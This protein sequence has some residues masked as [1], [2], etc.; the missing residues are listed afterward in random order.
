VFRVFGRTCVVDNAKTSTMSLTDSP[1]RH[2]I[3]WNQSEIF[4]SLQFDSDNEPQDP[5]LSNLIAKRNIN[6]PTHYYVKVKKKL[7]LYP[8][9]THMRVDVQHH[10]I[11]TSALDEGVVSVTPPPPCPR[12]K[13]P[14]ARDDRRL[15]I[16]RISCSFIAPVYAGSLLTAWT[17]RVGL[18]HAWLQGANTHAR[19]S[20]TFLTKFCSHNNH[21]HGD[22]KKL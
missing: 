2:S 18:L 22:K 9:S 4:F 17:R 13:E 6:T 1:K 21:T 11:V 8:P 7:C 20:S 15:S 16:A 3:V 12:R 10:S 14:A 19:V 5:S